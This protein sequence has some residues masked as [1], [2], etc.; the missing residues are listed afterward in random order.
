[1][2]SRREELNTVA[3]CASFA[4][5]M[6]T[7]RQY[8]NAA[9]FRN[10]QHCWSYEEFYDMVR[11][12]A[13][14]YAGTDTRYYDIR[15]EHPF[16]FSVALFAVT[17]AGGAA[18]LGEAGTESER[19]APEPIV[20]ITQEDLMAIAAR[21]DTRRLPMSADPMAVAVIARSSGTTSVA[22]RVALS[23]H[24]LLRDAIASMQVFDF[25]QGM[26]Y[27]HILP[28]THL[29]GIVADLLI[30]LYTGGT[31]CFS[32]NLLEFHRGLR[33]FR[34]EHMNLPPAMVYALDRMLIDV[35]D[36]AEVTGGRLREIICAG[37]PLHDGAAVRL[38]EAGVQ[39][40]NAYGLTECSPCISAN[41]ARFHRPGSVG[42][43]LPCCEV[44]IVDEEVTVRGDNVMLGYWNDPDAT[45]RVMR[46]GWLYTG[47][48]G[49]IDADGYLY[50]TG[51]KSNLIVFEDGTKLIP[52]Q[53]E[54]AISVIPG[55]LECMVSGRRQG[56]RMGLR[57]IV[58]CA[59]SGTDEEL[60]RIWLRGLLERRGLI[61]RVNKITFSTAAL[62]KNALGKILRN[63]G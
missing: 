45:A 46:D 10:E 20:R 3:P 38:K 31:I 15:V 59:N 62:P 53:L 11:R 2:E 23:Q 63:R 18:L 21:T 16:W 26:V 27:Y 36:I 61:S 24:N 1:M 50:L 57:I 9:A 48:C 42:R 54:S 30:P 5:F 34:P 52:E 41:A 55:V 32:G 19:T 43:V 28:Y 51:R 39:V 44:R 8:G 37:A 49:Y 22:R 35:D 33:Q 47:D 29:F 7:I 25:R 58:V 14:Y 12:A 4:A 6:E 13:L 17:I 40:Y 56:G 60:I